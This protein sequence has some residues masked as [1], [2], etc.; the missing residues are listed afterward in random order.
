MSKCTLLH[1]ITDYHLLYYWIVNTDAGMC[2]QTSTAVA[3]QVS[4]LVPKLG[5]ESKGQSEGGGGAS[6]QRS[7][8]QICFVSLDI[9]LIFD[10]VVYY[11]I[12]LSL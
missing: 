2:E 10:F 7:A 1:S 12:K 4:L 11:K 8:T 5:V 3:G 6:K 9:C